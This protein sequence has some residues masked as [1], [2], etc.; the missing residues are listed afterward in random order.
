MS[1]NISAIQS[2][3]VWGLVLIGT[4]LCL[5]VGIWVVR[6]WMFAPAKSGKTD[7]VWSL[8][9]LRELQDEG[10]ISLAEFES[11]KAKMILAVRRKDGTAETAP[12]DDEVTR[13]RQ[14][15]ARNQIKRPMEGS[16]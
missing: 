16:R 14:K 12:P 7:G 11:L 4:V 2:V 5:A 8:Q 13:I 1:T 3:V 10:Q 6:R 15:A 9:Q